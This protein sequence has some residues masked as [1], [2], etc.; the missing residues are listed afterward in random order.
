MS[1]HNTTVRDEDIPPD[2][3]R[4]LEGL[5]ET[6][7]QGESTQSVLNLISSCL[8]STNTSTQ[9]HNNSIPLTKIQV[10]KHRNTTFVKMQDKSTNTDPLIIL[11]PVDVIT[12]HSGLHVATYNP[13]SNIFVCTNNS[14]QIIPHCTTTQKPTAVSE[15][16][17]TPS[18]NEQ[19]CSIE[20]PTTC[21]MTKVTKRIQWNK[22]KISELLRNKLQKQAQSPTKNI[23]KKSDQ[24]KHV[25]IKHKLAKLV[26]RY[27]P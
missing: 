11:D 25:R 10:Q 16:N 9:T 12:L 8:T 23:P 14:K 20:A 6:L 3:F 13:F 17:H 27:Y 24:P 4:L 18:T 7:P 15:S 1:T 19:T 22:D 2:F 26:K 21:S 5:G